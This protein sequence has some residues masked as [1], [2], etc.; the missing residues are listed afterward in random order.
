MLRNHRLPTK[1]PFCAFL[2]LFF[3]PSEKKSGIGANAFLPRC[4]I[5]ISTRPQ[6][7]KSTST[8]LAS[9]HHHD[10]HDKRSKK[11]LLYPPEGNYKIWREIA[12]PVKHRGYMNSALSG[13]PS[14]TSRDNL[15]PEWIYFARVRVDGN[16]AKIL[17][18]EGLNQVHQMR[19]YL[20][21]P[22]FHHGSTAV[23]TLRKG[24]YNS[25]YEKLPKGLTK[26]QN[27]KRA[28][29]L[30]DE[31]LQKW[32]SRSPEEIEQSLATS[33]SIFHYKG[34]K[35]EWRFKKQASKRNARAAK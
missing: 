34:E 16:K 2:F 27:R 18:F 1:A 8:L 12:D 14:K 19:A 9:K 24:V 25:W 5:N 17:V 10:K 23:G 21:K 35:K 29:K 33:S 7:I 28:L 4:P 22:P 13:F 30:L 32:D 6:T 3:V 26:D 11:E 31:I 20:S 15:V